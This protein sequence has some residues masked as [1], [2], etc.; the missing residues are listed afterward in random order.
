MFEDAG[1]MVGAASAGAAL[2]SPPSVPL[3]TESLASLRRVVGPH[4]SDAALIPHLRGSRK[5]DTA[6][7]AN[8]YLRAACNVG[9][10]ALFDFELKPS[11]RCRSAAAVAAAGCELS[12]SATVVPWLQLESHLFPDITFFAVEDLEPLAVVASS[13]HKRVMFNDIFWQNTYF[14]SFGEPLPP[15]PTRCSS[16]LQGGQQRGFVPP[17]PRLQPPRPVAPRLGE[18]TVSSSTAAPR[19]CS[20][21]CRFVV[22]WNQ[23]RR[24]ECPSCGASRAVVPVLHGFPHA[25]LLLLAR[26]GRVALTENCG[27]LGPPWACKRCR[28]GWDEYPW[29]AARPASKSMPWVYP[30][31]GEVACDDGDSS[32]VSMS[33]LP[34]VVEATVEEHVG[35]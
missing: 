10:D 1:G 30:P 27:M 20:A 2:A 23:E 7:A 22:R 8:C 17:E 18:N 4:A 21:M 24:R 32:A 34:A 26:Q 3:T 14:L 12:S 15:L 6:K 11:R 31:P 16:S 13:L 33:D 29:C 25:S 35:E 5:G 19:G 9:C 28:Q